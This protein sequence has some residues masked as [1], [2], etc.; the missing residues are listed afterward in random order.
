MGRKCTFAIAFVAVTLVGCSESE[1]PPTKSEIVNA[2]EDY[3]DSTVD[4]I[5]NIDC[6]HAGPSKYMCEFTIS[7]IGSYPTDE[8]HC[9][10]ASATGWMAVDTFRCR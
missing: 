6:E 5:A 9:M 10:F 7:Y 1:E 8:Q 2:M 3:A 4:H